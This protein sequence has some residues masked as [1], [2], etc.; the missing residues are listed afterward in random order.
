MILVYIIAQGH[1]GSTLMD[2]ILGTHPEFISNGEL[3]YLNWQLERTKDQKKTKVETQTLCTCK[4]DFRSC[5]YW[6][7]VFDEV[8]DK[9]NKNIAEEPTSFDTAYFGEFSFKERGGFKISKENKNNEKKVYKG[10]MRGKSLED[11]LKIEPKIIDWLKN[12]WLLYESMSKVAD[13]SVVIDSS[14][15]FLRMLLLQKYRPKD[16][17]VIFINRNS[18]GLTSSMKRRLKKMG[19]SEILALPY[20][21]FTKLKYRFKIRA[22]KKNIKDLTY[23]EV[24]YDYFVSKPSDFL[25]K[26][27]QKLELKNEYKKQVN[28][29]FYIDPSQ[30]HLVAGNPMRYKGRQK[31][32]YDNRW[33]K[34]LNKIELLALNL[35]FGEK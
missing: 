1:T 6:S 17:M 10:L 14:K 21:I 27:V 19:R 9:S 23:L 33:K 29:S 18:R 5:D 16:V 22:I 28:E 20:V 32:K 26:V 11:M 8:K 7:K 31:V 12:N 2:C 13:K 30:Q 15:S 4:K 34:S 24:D 25:G 35:F 3:M